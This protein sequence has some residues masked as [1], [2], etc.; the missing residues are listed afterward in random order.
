MGV[1]QK[2]AYRFGFLKSEKWKN[3]RIEAC[4]H[5]RG[6]CF[7]CREY[8]GIFGDVHHLWY[9]KGKLEVEDVRLLCRQCHQD[10]HEHTTPKTYKEITLATARFDDFVR[11]IS[12]RNHR[13]RKKGKRTAEFKK[14]VL[15]VRMILS[16]EISEIQEKRLSEMRNLIEVAKNSEHG[17]TKKVLDAA[18]C[19]A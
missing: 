10:A 5:Y 3:F 17:W 6:K 15:H 4:S 16:G 19:L 14:Q 11:A 9:P 2:H 12:K 8:V 18:M 7:V 1:A 13:E